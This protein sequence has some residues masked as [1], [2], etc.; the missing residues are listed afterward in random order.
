MPY[1]SPAFSAARTLSRS[2]RSPPL[3]APPP[4]SAA[5]PAC[6]PPLDSGSKARGRGARRG[7]RPRPDGTTLAALWR[8][9]PRVFSLQPRQ[10]V[11]TTR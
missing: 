2:R 9:R 5:A 10:P 6:R 1:S 8:L 3:G 11:P 7:A 4:D